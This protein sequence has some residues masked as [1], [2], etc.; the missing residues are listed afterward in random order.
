MSRIIKKQL[1]N[2]LENKVYLCSFASRNNICKSLL[3]CR[4]K[5]EIIP[6]DKDSKK[7]KKKNE[8]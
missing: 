6:E 7:T 3:T 4:L 5:C 1:L 8:E 2:A